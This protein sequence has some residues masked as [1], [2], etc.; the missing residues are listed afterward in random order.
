MGASIN[1]EWKTTQPPKNR[2]Q[3][4]PPGAWKYFTGQIFA[5]DYAVGKTKILFSSHGWIVINAMFHHKQI[6]KSN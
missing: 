6:L 3:P 1:N 2:Q 5:L 4:R